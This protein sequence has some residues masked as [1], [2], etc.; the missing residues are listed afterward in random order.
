M[1]DELIYIKFRY[2]RFDHL[3]KILVYRTSYFI[4]SKKINRTSLVELVELGAIL[5][6]GI[7]LVSA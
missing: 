5:Y 7:F 1:L 2:M 3:I 4:F 6:L